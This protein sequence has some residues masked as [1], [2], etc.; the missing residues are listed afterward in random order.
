MANSDPPNKRPYSNTGRSN[1]SQF[2]ITHRA[3]P[4]LDGKHTVFGGVVGPQDQAVVNAIANG[5]KIN[6]VK[7]IR[8]GD[9]AKAFKGDEAHFKKLLADKEKAKGA[10]LEEQKKKET[11]QVDQLIDSLKKEHQAEVVTSETGLRYVVTKA[12]EGDAP[13]KGD[14]LTAHMVFRLPSGKVMLDTRETKMPKQISVGA[15]L[16]INGLEEG[17]VGMK[18]G[19]RRTIIIPPKLGF[20]V[21]GLAENPPI[22][23]LIF[24]VEIVDVQSDKKQI[25]KIINKLKKDYPKAKLITTKSGLQYV[26]TKVGAGDKVGKGKKIKAHYTGRLLDGTEF[27]SSVKR[28]VPFEFVVGTGQVIKGWDEALSDMKKGEKRTLIIPPGLAYGPRGRPGIPP[29]ATLVF[30]VELVDF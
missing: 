14:R 8:I 18:K 22:A 5:D 19:E 29:N 30:D 15:D 26:V 25:E 21:E 6:H 24:E 3:T 20:G 7:I 2:F 16:Q 10:A 28:G 13:A 12:G 9:K 1:G 17:L 4:H 11:G 27:D 23:T